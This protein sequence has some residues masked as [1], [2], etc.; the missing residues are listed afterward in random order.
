MSGLPS[1]QGIKMLS[2]SR[3]KRDAQILMINFLIIL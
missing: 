3:W 2:E 1:R